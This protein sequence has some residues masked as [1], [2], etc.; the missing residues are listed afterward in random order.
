MLGV[1][2]LLSPAPTPVHNLNTFAVATDYAYAGKL[3]KAA[4]YI[5]PNVGVYQKIHTNDIPKHHLI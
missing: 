5:H 2:F 4:S 1:M 3:E